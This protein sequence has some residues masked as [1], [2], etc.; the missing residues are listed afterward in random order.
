M[1]VYIDGRYICSIRRLP[2]QGN[3]CIEYIV[4]S[5]SFASLIATGIQRSLVLVFLGEQN[6]LEQ[7]NL[8]LAKHGFNRFLLAFS[9]SQ[10][11]C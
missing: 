8:K 11:A 4:K 6:V 2:P 10:S 1:S 5:I 3:L 7:A 9:T